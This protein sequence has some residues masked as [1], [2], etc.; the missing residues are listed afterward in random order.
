[1][2]RMYST[3]VLLSLVATACSDSPTRPTRT[4]A[5]SC[6]ARA[7]MIAAALAADPLPRTLPNGDLIDT[8]FFDLPSGERVYIDWRGRVS[9]VSGP[10]C[11][12]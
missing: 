1:M 10:E 5:Y 4:V 8:A 11:G 3:L 2:A 12:Q 6:D 7:T 9:H